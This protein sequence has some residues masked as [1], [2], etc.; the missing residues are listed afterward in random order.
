[1]SRIP[2]PSVAVLGRDIDVG[3][4]VRKILQAPG[5]GF[6]DRHHPNAEKRGNRE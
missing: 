1:M 4:D 6:V 3:F 5:I 2:L